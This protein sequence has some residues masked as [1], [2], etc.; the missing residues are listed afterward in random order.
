MLKKTL[1]RHKKNHG[2]IFQLES[3]VPGKTA[4]VLYQS[5]IHPSVFEENI[6]PDDHG[7][8]YLKAV[9]SWI[10]PEYLQH[11]KTARWWVYAGIVLL[12]AIIIEA[13]TGSW[14]M[15]LATVV[16]AGVYA[17]MHEFQ[18][19]RHTKIVLSD[20]G[21]K[22]GNQKIPYSGIESFWVL[23][24]PPHTSTLNFRL[25]RQFFPDLVIELEDQ[26]PASVRE[27]LT[28]FVPELTNQK[29]KTTDLILRLLKL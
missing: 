7:D 2:Q 20:I 12:I 16:F 10:A 6:G 17:Y 25:R 27:Y 23:Y 26:D 24:E 28:S 5:Q 21:I 13:L 15:I 8:A 1:K 29:A 18:P 22:V 11:P 3:P 14:T 19:P 4:K 9:F